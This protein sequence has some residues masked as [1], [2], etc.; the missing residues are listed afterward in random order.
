MEKIDLSLPFWQRREMLMKKYKISYDF[1]YKEYV[2]RKIPIERMK[3]YDKNTF[4]YYCFMIRE[5]LR[6]IKELEK[7]KED[8]RVAYIVKKDFLQML[9]PNWEQKI[10]RLEREIFDYYQKFMKVYEEVKEPN[11]KK[12]K[13]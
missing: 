1:L 8:E 4:D 2:L 10:G 11:E 7:S 9:G 6:N 3:V 13:S 5:T 12:R